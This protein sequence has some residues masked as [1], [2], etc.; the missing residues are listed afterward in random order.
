MKPH[1]LVSG[2]NGPCPKPQGLGFWGIVFRETL[3]RV[4]GDDPPVNH[5]P[6]LA[7]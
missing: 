2:I 1:E 5:P 4:M 3:N 7:F 6:V